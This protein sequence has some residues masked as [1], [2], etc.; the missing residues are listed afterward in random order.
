M[1]KKLIFNLIFVVM[2]ILGF[3]LVEMLLR[4]LGFGYNTEPFLRHN[5][6]R[7]FYVDNRDFRLKYYPRR[8]DLKGDPIKNVFMFYKPDGVLRGFVIGG[9][10]AEGFPFYSNHSFSKILES[11]LSEAKRF[12]KVEVINLGFSAM[13]SYYVADVSKKILKYKPDFV[14]IYSG[15]NEYYGTIS[16]TTGGGYIAKK[17]YLA[18]KELRIFQLIFEAFGQSRWKGIRT[19][20]MMAEQF[21]NNVIMPNDRFDKRVAENYIRNIDEVVRFFT[22]KGVHVILVEPVCNL[23]DMPPF[24]GVGDD[25]YSNIIIPY[26]N[27]IVLHKLDEVKKYSRMISQFSNSFE[28]ANIL[29]LEALKK[30]YFDKVDDVEAFKNAKDKD[31]IP[32]RIRSVV[33][34]SLNNYVSRNQWNKKLHFIPLEKILLSNFGIKAFGNSFFIDHLHFNF[35][36][37]ILLAGIIARKIADIYNFSIDE[38]NRVIE[39]LSDNS[40]IVR[41]IYFTPL[42]SFL[43]YRSILILTK[44]PPYSDMII[45]FVPSPDLLNPFLTNKEAYELSEEEMFNRVIN[46]YVSKRDF[47][48]ALFYMNSV[49]AVYPAEARNHLAMAELQSMMGDGE[50]IYNYILAYVLSDRDYEYYER[51]KN[52]LLSR[53]Q[54]VMLDNILSKYG[55][56]RERKK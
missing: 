9:S 36:G 51:L 10:A 32:F 3:V 22:S 40:K 23:V 38:R 14:V 21:N 33:A 41:N 17:V 4:I 13:S 18:L 28:N 6:I 20:T 49:V 42:H 5:K 16:A 2:V 8:I 1:N 11:A 19:T 43:G 48:N 55:R 37:H 56:P 45:R 54:T 39:Y 46:Q 15:H 12:R 25:K 27:S 29:Y 44:H 7:E 26:Y 35:N 31:I 24:R 52:Y 53:H 34:E 47:T 50:A 30:M